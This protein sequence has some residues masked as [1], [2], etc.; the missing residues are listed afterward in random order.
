MTLPSGAKT[1]PLAADS[2]LTGY[3]LMVVLLC[4]FINICDGLDTTATSFAAPVLIQDWNLPAATMGS[5]LSIG[6]AGLMVGALLVSPQAD[7]FGRRPLIIAATLISA[8]AMFGMGFSTSLEMLVIFRFISGVAVGSLLPSLSVMVIEYSNEARG[9]MFL[10]IVHIGFAIGAM[11]GGALGSALLGDYGWR[12]IFLSAGCLT[13]L[14]G[15]ASA[16]LL[17]ESLHFLVTRQPRNALQRANRLLTRL[18]VQTLD[19]L[20]E[21]T[22]PKRNAPIPVRA[23]FTKMLVAATLFLWAAAFLRYF[24]SYFLT[25]WKPQLFVLSGFTPENA[26]MVGIFTS[27]AAAIGVLTM[28]FAA[29]RLGAPRAAAITFAMCAISLFGFGM[30]DAPAAL[31]AFAVLAMFS[32]EATFSGIM[33]T[34]A[35]LY[36]DEIRAT[37]VGFAV[38]I[39]RVGAIAGP[40][41]GGVVIGMGLDRSSV[42]PIYAVAAILGTV[43]ILCVGAHGQFRR[44]RGAITEVAE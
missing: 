2:P 1:K 22:V 25:S 10:A 38:G 37:G 3:Q 44:R 31:I 20:P 34:A 26:A 43:A 28:G 16:V 27:F 19:A 42:M 12:S 35:R 30:F 39:G 18:K 7:R 29:T 8:L 41:F 14:A 11:L 15:L 33:I 13:A 5:I 4:V 6:S 24:V 21:K 23:L 40:Y 17:P 36:P 32:V 9:N